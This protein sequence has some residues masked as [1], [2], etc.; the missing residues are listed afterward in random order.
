MVLKYLKSQILHFQAILH[1][2]W[3]LLETFD[4]MNMWKFLHYIN[5]SCLVPNG[6]QLFIWGE[7]YIFS[8]SYN[9]TSDDLWPWYMTFDCISIQ[10]IPYCIFKLSLVPIGPQLFKWGHFHIYNLTSDDFW[11]WYMTFDLT[12]LTNESSHVASMNQ[13]WSL[14]EQSSGETIN[15]GAS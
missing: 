14:C 4:L 13:L 12:S 15:Y 10:R 7:F 2:L 8:T 6:H 1:D 3:H 9:L 5:K 11:P